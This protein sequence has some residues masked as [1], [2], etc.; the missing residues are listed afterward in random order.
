MKTRERIRTKER[1]NYL[2]NT[3]ETIYEAKD[4]IIEDK[5]AFDAPGTGLS[6]V[7]ARYFQI[8]KTINDFIK[9]IATNYTRH[10]A[11]PILRSGR[12]TSSNSVL[13]TG[14]IEELAEKL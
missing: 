5:L 2:V 3:E 10:N 14:L 12:N 9:K 6:K 13:R 7:G 1:K 11:N 8:K 4:T